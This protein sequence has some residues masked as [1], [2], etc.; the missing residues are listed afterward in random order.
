MSD[1][2]DSTVK[3]VTV[4]EVDELGDD[5]GLRKLNLFDSMIFR[6]VSSDWSG[7]YLDLKDNK[8]VMCS[9]QHFRLLK[10]K[11]G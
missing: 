11:E 5:G 3:V 4:R 8:Y 6:S 10:N 1:V 7:W 2:P 9:A